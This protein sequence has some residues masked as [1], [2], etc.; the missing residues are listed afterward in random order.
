MTPYRSI[1]E[2]MSAAHPSRG[3]YDPRF[4][5]DGCGVAF[6]ARVAGGATH[7]VVDSGIE[8]LVNL[9]HR[10]ASGADADTGDGAGILVPLPDLFLREVSRV[11]LPQP[12]AYGVGVGFFPRD[13]R[14]RAECEAITESAC[15]DEG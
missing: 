9:G 14:E 3:L 8:A 11:A 6:V 13:A 15:A 10:G 4:D 12:G 2:Q 7:S 1:G 5:H